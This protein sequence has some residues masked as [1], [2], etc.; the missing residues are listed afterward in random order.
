MTPQE[1]ADMQARYWQSL[2][3]TE[4]RELQAA[5]GII[6]RFRQRAAAKG[7]HLKDEDFRYSH[8]TG[9][10]ACH[11]QLLRALLDV[12]PD[13]SDGLYR[14]SDLKAVLRPAKFDGGCLQADEF[15]VFAHSCFR[16]AMH[17]LNNWAP[18]FIDMFWRLEQPG[19]EKYVALD[20]DRVRIDVDGPLIVELDTWYGPPFNQDIARIVPGTTKLRPPAD[21]DMPR[22]A[23]WY[24]NTYCVDIKWTNGPVRTFQALE[25][26]HEDV[27]LEENGKNWHPA[28]YLHAEYDVRAQSFRHFDGAIQYL[29]DDEYRLRKDSDFNLIYKSQ[30]HVKPKSKK[31]FKLNGSLDVHT[32]VELASHFYA[33]N[34][35]MFEYFNQ[36]TPPPHVADLLNRLRSPRPK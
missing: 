21:L 35:L 8:T 31:V 9:I 5:A 26:K 34:P 23:Y 19:L 4:K 14:W 12:H 1:E 18:F 22:I 36:G 16:R 2:R 7:I 24:A 3:E 27:Q 13:P 28:R 11:P 17:P 29:N 6:E 33:A 20:E 15:V 10:T 32:W 30:L 25:L